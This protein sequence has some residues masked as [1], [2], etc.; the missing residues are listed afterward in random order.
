MNVGPSGRWMR[1]A[2]TCRDAGVISAQSDYPMGNSL[3]SSVEPLLA[4][5][6]VRCADLTDRRLRP[7]RRHPKCVGAVALPSGSTTGSA[8]YRHRTRRIW[9]GH[10]RIRRSSTCQHATWPRWD[11]ALRGPVCARTPPWFTGDRRQWPIRMLMAQMERPR[12][13]RS[14]R[15]DRPM[16]ASDMHRSPP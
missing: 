2:R 3:P 5:G 4:S 8:A 7:L 14:V 12:N 11:N 15:H 6:R 16:L 1:A 9:K 13:R 10:R